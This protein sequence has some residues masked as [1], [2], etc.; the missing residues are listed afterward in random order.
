MSHVLHINSSPRADRS[1]SLN[2]AEQFL[3]AYEEQ[4][5]DVRI[6]RLNLFQEGLPE[7]GTDAAEAKMAA[8]IGADKTSE[9][10][11]AWEDAREVF[12]RFDSADRYVFNVPMWNHGVPYALKHWIDIVTQPGWSFG[13]DPESGY[14]GLLEGKKAVVIYSSALFVPGR[15]QAF[16]VDFQSTYFNDWLRF[17]GIT[18]VT[19]VRILGNLDPRSA[20]AIEQAE[21]QLQELATT[22]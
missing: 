18:D 7:F 10:V 14:S 1:R 13:F 15:P 3:T 21:G 2:L 20:A 19:E 8:F 11:K 17:V 5:S 12:V 6:D 16:G 9:Q 4:R 22:F